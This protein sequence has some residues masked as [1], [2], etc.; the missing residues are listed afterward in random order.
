MNSSKPSCSL[1][2]IN[3]LF[4][5]LIALLCKIGAEALEYLNEQDE[6]NDRDDH[7]EVFIAIVAVVD[8][9]LAETAAADDAA[10]CRVA[11][12]GG[13]RD[14]DVLDQR[15]HALGDHDLADYL[16]GRRAHALRGLDDVDVKLA[17]AALY[18]ACNEWKRRRDERND[19]RRRADGRAYERPGER[20]NHYHENK[21]WDRAQKVYYNVQ[22][23]H[24]P[25]GQRPNAVL[26]AGDEQNT[27]RKPYDER[28]SGA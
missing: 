4:Q 28:K 17:Q 13:Q 8:G 9:N 18:K 19:G 2:F 21:E 22:Q 16:E 3:I 5:P 15:G 11:E 20:K 7:D 27:E 10:H 6:D 1:C 25:A 14:G 26:F 23:V 24:E 12:Y